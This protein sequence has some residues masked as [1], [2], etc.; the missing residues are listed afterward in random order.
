MRVDIKQ[1]KHSPGRKLV[2]FNKD[3]SPEV[4]EAL[5]NFWES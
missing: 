5:T 4:I 2:R 3:Q 1:N